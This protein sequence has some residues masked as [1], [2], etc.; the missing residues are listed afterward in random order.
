ME[1]WSERMPGNQGSREKTSAPITMTQKRA[2]IAA[3]RANGGNVAQAMRAAG[4]SSRRTAYLWLHRFEHDGEAA[5]EPRSHAR[6]RRGQIA[7]D[8]ADQICQTRTRHPEWGRR[9][10]AAQVSADRGGEI[11][12]PTGVEAVLR[13]N[14]L[15]TALASHSAV[16][17]PP[18][19]VRLPTGSLDLDALREHM[20]AGLRA[21]VASD[22]RA[23]VRLLMQHVWRPLAEQDARYAALLRDSTYARW[24]M[25]ALVQLGHSF[26]NLGDWA[27][28][29]A[30]LAGMRHA[31]GAL[32]PPPSRRGYEGNAEGCSLDWNDIWLDCYQYLGIVWREAG[33][34]EATGYLRTALLSCQ[35]RD[36]AG[37]I[38]TNYHGHRANIERDM[39]KLKLLLIRRGH[40]ID[41]AEVGRHLEDALESEERAGN[42][43]ML[44]ATH[45]AR[46]GLLGERAACAKGEERSAW[47]AGLSKM[48]RA[49]NLA[50]ELV[51]AE[52]SPM[53]SANFAIDA[54]ELHLDHD[55]PVDLPLLERAA[56]ICLAFGYGGQARKLIVRPQIERLLA[57]PIREQLFDRFG[58]GLRGG[59]RSTA[60]RRS[61]EGF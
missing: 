55:M 34:R 7:D 14:G 53:L 29:R 27:L 19:A 46:A 8:L 9:R 39:G 56:Q 33:A 50:L 26:M 61:S 17:R 11:V 40:R 22:A 12:S 59:W 52:R 43:G 47:M 54:A 38:P 2:L 35:R 4:I 15:W 60:T 41:L 16:K 28:A 42:P 23:A 6:K 31:L 20:R 1:E 32:E 57:A 3:H 45:M 44:A 36:A 37:H 51:E 25:R 13:R 24:L 30:V 5:L 58:A 10:I 48:D 18:A 49:I 21:S